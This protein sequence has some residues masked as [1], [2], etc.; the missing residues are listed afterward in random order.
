MIQTYD[1]RHKQQT[2]KQLT[3]QTKDHE[4]NFHDYHGST[5]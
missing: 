2:D 3:V 5:D 4:T 1:D